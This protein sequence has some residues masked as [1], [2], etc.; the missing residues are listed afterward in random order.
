MILF[1]TI[2]MM[3]FVTIFMKTL[4]SKVKPQAY[5]FMRGFAV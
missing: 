3:V 5:F 1:E 2:L 4:A